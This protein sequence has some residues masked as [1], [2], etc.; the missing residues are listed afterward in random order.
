MELADSLQRLLCAL[1]FQ[2]IITAKLRCSSQS[3][4]KIGDG[5]D[6]VKK[7]S[8]KA[9]ASYFKLHGC[10]WNHSARPFVRVTKM[11]HAA[12]VTIMT[13][14]SRTQA[15]R[16]SHDF[17]GARIKVSILRSS[18][19]KGPRVSGSVSQNLSTAVVPYTPSNYCTSVPDPCSNS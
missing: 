3:L 11:E 7:T 14:T 15:M 12:T 5:E 18:C 19:T 1:L 17:H 8:W 16:R 4:F 10:A 9:E 2:K 13:G 6:V